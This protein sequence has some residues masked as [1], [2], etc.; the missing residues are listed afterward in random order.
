MSATPAL[1]PP[2]FSRRTLLGAS[3][4]GLALLVTGCTASPADVR[5][6]VTSEQA[7]E[8][9]AQL[10]VQEAL[11]AAYE[12]A[13]KADPSLAAGVKELAAQAGEQLER[14]RDAAPGT[15]P[16][17]SP[18]AAAA[19]AGA[20]AKGWLRQQV[21]AAAT[22]HATACVDQSGPRAALLGSIAAGL[23]GQ[24]GLLA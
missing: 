23:R 3:A 7:D 16:S 6:T 5:K 21:A 9:A 12:S 15:T 24:D 11:V 20:A 13:A 17:A 2:G 14:L 10:G 8:L 22:S 1:R 4:A 19:P 18:S